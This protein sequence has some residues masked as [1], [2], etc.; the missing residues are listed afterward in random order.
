MSK[1]ERSEGLPRQA[2]R[3]G[4][5]AEVVEGIQNLI[6]VGIYKPGD[7][8]P[9][10]RALSEQLGVS[11]PTAREAI[12]ALATMNILEVRRGSGVY[13]SPLAL[14]DLLQPLRF[15][16]ELNQPAL[17][18][19]F[20]VRLALEPLAAALAAERASREEVDG[21]FACID[22]ASKVRVSPRRLVELD[23]ELH[24]RIVDAAQNDLLINLI[25]SLSFLSRQSREKTVRE[26]GIASVTLLDHRAIVDAIARRNSS[27][28]EAAMR[29][30]LVRIQSATRVASRPAA[31]KAAP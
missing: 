9:S 15:A 18:S 22:R 11:R 5:A 2:T 24:Q 10:E 28:A 4:V 25:A 21:L 31:L 23:T 14:S 1:A 19:L 29:Q 26:P 16:I 6:K 7:R 13:V 8:L 12:Q 27:D 20:E 17:S 3:V 30:H